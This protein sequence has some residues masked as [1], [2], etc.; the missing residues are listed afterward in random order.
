MFEFW[1]FGSLRT[2]THLWD[3]PT[4]NPYL[5]FEEQYL[6]TNHVFSLKHV[7]NIYGNVPRPNGQAFYPGS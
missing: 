7:L 2:H 6:Q 5:Y 1:I 3:F 4:H